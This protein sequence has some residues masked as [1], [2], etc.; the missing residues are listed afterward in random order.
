[1][2]ECSRCG[3]RKI[4]Y[5]SCRNRHCPKCQG[6]KAFEWVEARKAELLPVEYFHTVFTLPAEFNALCLG[7]KRLMY[8]LMFKAASRTL[9]QL[10]KKNLKCNIGFFA[11]LH[12][13]GSSM[14]LHPHLHVVIPGC[15][16]SSDGRLVRFKTHYFLPDRIISTVFRGK[17][18]E[19]LKKAK[20]KTELRAEFDDFEAFLSR[21]VEHDWVVRTKPPFA[22]PEVVLKYL[23][24]YVQ[25]I[26]I[27]NKRIRSLQNGAV[28]FTC[29]NYRADGS[30]Q[31]IKLTATDFIQRFL[32]HAVPHHFVRIRFFGFLARQNKKLALNQLRFALAQVS[33]SE[34]PASITHRLPCPYCKIGILKIIN[35]I[36]TTY[37][38]FSRPYLSG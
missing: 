13:W 3:Y 34:K 21:S 16:L 22:G 17:F 33:L 5:N 25:R 27:S 36:S 1:M 7:N 28:A 4:A 32:L 37:H 11:I 8:D 24:R 23:S 10:G 15:G 2:Y 18:I 30:K 19:L 20:A 6:H 26:A 38:H 9:L 12:T 14:A 29:K 35:E 31:E